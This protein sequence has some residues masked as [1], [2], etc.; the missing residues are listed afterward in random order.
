M[1]SGN[2]AWKLFHYLRNE[3]ADI[4]TLISYG[5]VQSNMLPPLAA[6]ARMKGWK[7][8]FYVDQIPLHLQKIPRGNYKEAIQ[9]GAEVIPLPKRGVSSTVHVGSE[10]IATYIQED[11]L[12]HTRGVLFIDE[13]GRGKEAEEGIAHWAKEIVAAVEQAGLRN[14]KL[15][16]PSGTGTSAFYLQRFLPFEVFTNPCVGDTDYLTQQFLALSKHQENLPTILPPLPSTYRPAGTYHFG[17][18]NRALYDLWAELKRET[19]ITF[20][21]L[22]DPMGW[23]HTLAYMEQQGKQQG[24]QQVDAIYLHQGGLTGNETM[25]ARYAR[26]WPDSCPVP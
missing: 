18:L 16:L 12:P 25:L 14:P 23:L 24:E 15:F 13:G 20:D 26:K 19:G 21:L 6:L 7:L 9:L 5:S 1:Y 17:K 3:F 22:Y 8:T 10:Q 2:K 11:V 4:S